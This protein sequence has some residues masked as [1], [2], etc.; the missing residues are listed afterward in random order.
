MGGSARPG[1][2]ERCGRQDDLSYVGWAY[3]CKQCRMEIERERTQHLLQVRA[4]ERLE[5][6]MNAP[7][8]T[9]R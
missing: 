6:E 1:G 2:C 8:E 4:L 5:Q 9:R 7:K 3:Y